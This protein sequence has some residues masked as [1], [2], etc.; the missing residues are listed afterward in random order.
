MVKTTEKLLSAR[1]WVT[2]AL[3]GTFCY[4]TIQGKVPAEGF[5]AVLV[6]TLNYYFKEKNRGENQNEKNNI[7]INNPN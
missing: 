5:I 3:T 6:L 4:I 2:L 1:F 7:D